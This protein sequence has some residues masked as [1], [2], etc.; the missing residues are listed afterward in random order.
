M[1]DGINEQE[2]VKKILSHKIFEDIKS[3]FENCKTVK[4]IHTTLLYNFP[5]ESYEMREARRAIRDEWFDK[6]YKHEYVLA[7]PKVRETPYKGDQEFFRIFGD[8]GPEYTEAVR[9]RTDD[10]Y[11]M[12]YEPRGYIELH[13]KYVQIITCGLIKTADDK[14]VI[15]KRK[16]GEFKDKL[17]LIM[18]HCSYT[19]ETYKAIKNVFTDE[20]EWMNR[21]LFDF[22]MMADLKRE[23]HEEAGIP[24]NCCMRMRNVSRLYIEP[25]VDPK[26]IAY[27]HCGFIYMLQTDLIGDQIK[28]GEP[29]N[30]DVVIMTADELSD[31]KKNDTDGWLYD[32]LYMINLIKKP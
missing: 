24:S 13:P 21:D 16:Y 14:Y 15:L 10:A 4:D 8:F 32:Y 28:S 6:K 1:S 2:A 7:I 9:S 27:Y 31:L 29:E 5:I 12:G 20:L 26:N 30:N 18:G 17:T 19:P 11:K 22:L 3:L 23:I 25:G